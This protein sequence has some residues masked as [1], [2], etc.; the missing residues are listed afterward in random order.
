MAFG[1]V[2]K[3]ALMNGENWS[4]ITN[5]PIEFEK[6]LVQIVNLMKMIDPFF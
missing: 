5:E 1:H 4:L 3:S 2:C 6:K